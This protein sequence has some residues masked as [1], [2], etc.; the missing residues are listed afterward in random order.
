MS[1]YI[2]SCNHSYH[3]AKF[4]GDCSHFPRVIFVCKDHTN[5][6]WLY[7]AAP[8]QLPLQLFS[9]DDSINLCNSYTMH[10]YFWFTTI[11]EGKRCHKGPFQWL[12]LVLT[13]I[14]ALFHKSWTKMRSC[15]FLNIFIPITHLEVRE[16]I[17]GKVYRKI[18]PMESWLA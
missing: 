2:C 18:K 11:A 1:H 5:W 4:A 7:W 17:T 16:M 9:F 6:I 14:M 10:Y 15:Q 13:I 8:L 3:L 12:H